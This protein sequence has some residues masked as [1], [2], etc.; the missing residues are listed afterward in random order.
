MFFENYKYLS[1][2]REFGVVGGMEE[3]SFIWNEFLYLWN[4][5]REFL[6]GLG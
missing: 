4:G 2:V 1:M 3:M 5:C 6:K